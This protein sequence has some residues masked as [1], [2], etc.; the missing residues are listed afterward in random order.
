M[1]RRWG[2]AL[3][4]MLLA[5]ATAATAEEP[6]QLRGYWLD[7]FNTAINNQA[8]VVAAVDAVARTNANALFVQARRRGDVWYVS[9]YENLPD[10]VAIAPGFD[11]LAAVIAEAHARGIQV[12][13][14]VPIAAIWGR[15]PVVLGPPSDP[16][17]VFN[18]HGGFDRATGRI[19]PGPD[20]WL[21]RTLLPDGGGI[22]FQGHRFG[23][24]FWVDLGH[25]DAARYVADLL[26]DLVERYDLDGLHLDRIRY[27]EFSAA[28]QTP[29]N[30]TSIGYNPTSVARFQRH[31][32]LPDGTPPP[33][34]NDIAWSQWR[35]DQVTA[36]VRRVY[37]ETIARKP[38]IVV[39]AATIA[40][41]GAPATW[42]SAEAY[43]RVYQDW[44]AWTEEGILD[45]TV[46]MLYQREHMPSGASAFSSWLA[47]LRQHQYNRAMAA[48]QGTFLNSIE[49]S[50][51]QTRRALAPAGQP[52][53]G[54]L[55]FS[56]A[57]PDGA[58]V[59]NPLALPAPVT[60]AK[61]G[62]NEFI[63]G[64]TTGASVSGAVR[65]ED[66]TANPIP[67][68]AAPAAVPVFPWKATPTVG[69]VKGIVRDEQGLVLDTVA[70][71]LLRASDGTTPAAGRSDVSTRTDGNGFYGGVDLSP[72]TWY[73]LVTPATGL[74]Y[75][76]C[77]I[78]VETG[79]V[80]S[81]DIPLDRSAPT[82]TLAVSPQ[83]IWPVNGKLVP[84][85]VAGVAED[86]GL[87]LAR[88]VVSLTDEY[89]EI[90]PAPVEVALS[91]G[92][93][94]WSATFLVPAARLGTDRDGRRFTVQVAVTDG[95]CN[96]TDLQGEARV[97]HDQRVTTAR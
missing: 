57:N 27:P 23:N 8:Q 76:S 66:A 10:G 73:A 55:F 4:A 44:R 77:P 2:Q 54:V 49:G 18:R 6:A 41:G 95:G 11:P 63:A 35:R 15:H 30:G 20:N 24:D 21:T 7:T 68:F 58:V 93:A 97:P 90:A 40:F 69:H 38:Q 42:T 67:V 74:P 88:V 46:P 19:T 34:Q 89:G 39:S 32:G 94:E 91:G 92:R 31:R 16:N 25:P 45:V 33:P 64:Y 37:L 5:G 85:T 80:T 48:G 60:T 83:R 78:R 59:N 3:L 65:Y 62:I 9:A 13:A 28:G 47:F 53:A 50:L 82:S 96:R 52:L 43:W 70:V 72:G 86:A 22:T 29:S 36:V 1:A 51:R 81:A 14:F 12:H 17:H 26:I 87:G 84:V 61:R 79:R 71:A 75:R 56:L